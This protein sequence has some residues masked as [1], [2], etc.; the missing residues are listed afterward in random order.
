[1]RFF[2]FPFIFYCFCLLVLAVY[3]LYALGWPL[4]SIFSSFIN[5]LLLLPIIKK[6]VFLYSENI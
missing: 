6:E 4:G 2:V 3:F 5:F 1:M